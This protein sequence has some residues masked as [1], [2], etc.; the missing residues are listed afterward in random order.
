MR[1]AQININTP[2]NLSGLKFSD[3]STLASAIV[4]RFLAFAILAA[5]LF[6]FVKL[7][8]AGYTYLTSLGEPAKIQSASKELT[9]ATI[10]LII[11]IS[12][13]FL[14]QIIQVVFGINILI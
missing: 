8:S 9:N 4:S 14:A 1:L 6:F 7:I 5:G 2:P 10:G 13:F 11:V 3:Y 12:A